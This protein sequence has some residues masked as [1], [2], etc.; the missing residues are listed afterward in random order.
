[1]KTFIKLLALVGIGIIIY[2]LVRDRLGGEAD[3][4]V[5]TEVTPEGA[6]DPGEPIG[7]PADAA[8]DA[9]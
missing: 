7:D 6:G 1:M 8:A 3:E 4:F 9:A 5:F 2:M